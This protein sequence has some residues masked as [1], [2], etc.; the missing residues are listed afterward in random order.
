M[1]K[2]D[3]AAELARLHEIETPGA[4]NSSTEGLNETTLLYLNQSTHVKYY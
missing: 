3:D 4:N 1:D 2:Y